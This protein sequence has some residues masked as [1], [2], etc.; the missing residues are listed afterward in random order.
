M[1]KVHQRKLLHVLPVPN[2]LNG[3]KV[4]HYFVPV[5]EELVEEGDKRR[6][7]RRNGE[8]FYIYAPRNED[9]PP[10]TAELLLAAEVILDVDQRCMPLVEAYFCQRDGAQPP[11][12]ERVNRG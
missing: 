7:E 10:V 5:Y 12:R 2:P 4:G 8:P 11:V 9:A 6:L 3:H 1:R